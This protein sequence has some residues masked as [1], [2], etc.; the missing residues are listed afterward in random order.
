MRRLITL[1]LLGWSLFAHAQS[2]VHLR[3]IGSFSANAF[4]EGA[5][6]ISAYDKHSKL[7]F[8]VNGATGNIDVLDISSPG[9][10]FL[11][12]TINIAPYGTGANSVAVRDGIVAAAVENYNKQDNGFVVFFNTQGQYLKH[13][14]VGALPDMIIFTPDGK[15]LLVANEGEPSD[16]YAVDPLGTV[17]IIEFPNIQGVRQNKVTT[18][19]FS[20]YNNSLPAGIKINGPGASVAQDLEPEYIAVSEDSKRAFVTLQENNAVAVIDIHKKKVDSIYPL[21][22]QD[23]SLPGFGL[24][25][26]DQNSGVVD[27]KNWPVR[28]MYQPDAA[29]Y[30]KTM[31][32]K[33]IAYANEGDV[34]DYSG[35][36]EAKRVN[37]LNLDLTAF[38][39]AAVL[40]NN[41]NLGRLNVT[42]SL[43]NPDA[44]DDYD[45]LYSFGSRSVTIRDEAGN[46]IWDSGDFLE[47]KT[48]ELFP[49]NFN[50]SN[51]NNTK[52]NRSDDKGP[53][54]EGLIVGEILDSLYLFVGLERIGGI[55]V[56]NITDVYNPVFV[57]YFN[58]RDFSQVPGLNSGGDLGPEGMLFIEAKDSPNDKNLLVVSN[59]VSGTIAIYETD[60]LCGKK[61]EV[62]IC[63]NGTPQCVKA[64]ML[65]LYLQNGAVIGDCSGLRL[66]NNASATNHGIDW[67]ASYNRASLE[68]EM[69]FSMP[70]LD[71]ASVVLADL[72]GRVVSGTTVPAGSTTW[73]FPSD[74]PGGIYLLRLTGNGMDAGRKVVV[75]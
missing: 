27:I 72:T 40:K 1:S 71:E 70:L 3:K 48:F 16:D 68:L 47:Q 45:E 37:S 38:P 39:N 21:G 74:L 6:E 67:T 61:K 31:A 66:K 35:F 46:I 36:A 11:A 53:E 75:D 73:K 41:S 44:D 65:D 2:P 32:G 26:S 29:V 49:N 22:F 52:K 33:F 69:S 58:P 9:S 12:R 7:L 50:A 18:L 8:A 25:A 23:H 57:E 5:A 42:T 34:R 4:D 10:P 54:P 60:W 63:M 59:E 15:N 43:G 24:D 20:A 28:G 56:F 51:T 14:T 19:D 30:F 64:N 13:V 55:M 62:S 17:S